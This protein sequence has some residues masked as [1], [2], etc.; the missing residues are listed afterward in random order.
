[1]NRQARFPDRDGLSPN[2]RFL[3]GSTSYLPYPLPVVYQPSLF[4]SRLFLSWSKIIIFPRF[5]ATK[6][7]TACHTSSYVR[8]T[9]CQATNSPN[10]ITIYPVFFHAVV[11][12]FSTNHTPGAVPIDIMAILVLAGFTHRLIIYVWTLLESLFKR[13]KLTKAS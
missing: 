1:M 9:T 4:G 8:P 13:R 11:Q 5:P 10:L 2:A 7:I 6:R 12:I 3:T